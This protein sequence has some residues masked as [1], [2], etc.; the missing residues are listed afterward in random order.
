MRRSRAAAP[1]R[2]SSSVLDDLTKEHQLRIGTLQVSHG[3]GG[4]S[5]D[6]LSVDGERVSQSNIYARD[7]ANELASLDP[8]LRPAQIVTPWPIEAQ[9]FTQGG[10]ARRPDP[11][12]LRR[13][14]VI[15]TAR[16]AHGRRDEQPRRHLDERRI[17]APPRR[18]R[19]RR[20]PIRVPPHRPRRRHRRRIRARRRPPRRRHRRRIRARRRPPRRR[21][22]RRSPP[23]PPSG[24]PTAPPPPE[25]T[26]TPPRRAD[27]A[28]SHDRRSRPSRQGSSTPPDPTT[29][30]AGGTSPS[31]GAPPDPTTPPPEPTTAPSTPPPEPT[32]H[33]ARARRRPRP[34]HRRP[35]RAVGGDATPPEPATTP[36]SS[37]TTPPPEPVSPVTTPAAPAASADASERRARRRPG[38]RGPLDL[39]VRGAGHR[40]CRRRGGVG[41]P[42]VRP[43]C[44]RRATRRERHLPGR[45]RLPAGDRRVDGAPGPQGGPAG[46]AADH[47]GA[48]R[49]GPE[50]RQLRRPRLARLL[51]DADEHLEPGRVHGL[52]GPP[53]APAQVVHQPG[54]RGTARAPLAG[55][56]ELRAGQEQ[57]GRLGRRR[58][59]AGRR[60]PRPVPDPPRPGRQPPLGRAARARRA[61][62][63]RRGPTRLPPQRRSRARPAQP[64]RPR[65]SRRSRSRS[66]TS[67]RPTT[68]AATRRRPGST[69]R[70]SSS[71]ATRSSGSTSRASRPTSSTS[72]CTSRT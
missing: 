9:G 41:A 51:P 38:P 35:R 1:T 42:G 18:S 61:P 68:G 60:V 30:P 46:R 50:E 19:A 27:D 31:G 54:T 69:A 2:G 8:S 37:P 39:P 4:D 43:E 47:G 32:H 5:F 14:V 23:R 57:V 33:P 63:G 26:T 16:G 22:R 25:P 56:R 52:P 7:L 70:G 49:V 72:A 71:T 29:P 20:L 53:G 34:P 67:A 62:A 40:P 58:R 15:G 21:H 10:G 45:Q 64:A 12:H 36:P 6:I 24:G 65:A 48:H 44:G 3:A 17:P 66:A 55:R 28:S 13:P 59:A 11:H